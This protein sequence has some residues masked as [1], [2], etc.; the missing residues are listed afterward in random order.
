MG[1]FTVTTE[2]IY[3]GCIRTLESFTTALIH[4]DDITVGSRIFEDFDI[5]VR[6]YLSDD[7]LK[8]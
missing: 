1:K 8:I 3:I 4:E 5:Y 6:T 7:N 2:H